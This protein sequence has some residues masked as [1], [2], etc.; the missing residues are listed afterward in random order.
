MAVPIVTG[1]G[2]TPERSVDADSR[3]KTDAQISSG[4]RLIRKTLQ[5]KKKCPTAIPAT[6]AKSFGAKK[7]T[8]MPATRMPASTIDSRNPGEN[9]RCF[10]FQSDNHGS[11]G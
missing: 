9:G 10:I 5:K 6:I 7:A 1:H 2:G 8:P 4:F 3:T 11:H